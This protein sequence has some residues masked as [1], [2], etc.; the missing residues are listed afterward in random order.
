[1][2]NLPPLP[3]IGG[4]SEAALGGLG[5]IGIGA[6]GSAVSGYFGMQAEQGVTQSSQNIAKLQE[7]ANQ[8]NYNQ[9][10]MTI[11]RNSLQ[12]IRNAQTARATAIAGATNQGAQFGS[13]LAGGEAQIA[14][15]A[16]T[17]LLGLNQAASFAG[18]MNTV[19]Q[20]ISQ[21]EISKA[22]YQSTA[23]M[24]QG[25]GGMFGGL[26]SAG[27]SVVSA[28]TNPSGATQIK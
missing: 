23:N 14:G 21:Q 26:T 1:M 11:S 6:V 17:N 9:A 24:W 8:I 16:G 22:G 13:G 18:Q 5:A 20:G 19:N 27:N 15:Q 3:G 10:R 2:A 4:A 25:I 28:S 7:Q 12:E